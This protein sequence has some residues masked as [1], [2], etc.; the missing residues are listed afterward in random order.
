MEKSK[1]HT[2]DILMAVYYKDC[3]ILFDRAIESVYKNSLQPYRFILVVDGQLNTDLDCVI[4]K[5]GEL[6]NNFIVVRLRENLG[7]ANALNV[8]LT[9]S[10]AEYIIR[11][12]SDDYN[13]PDRFSI[14]MS[15][16]VSG[17]DVVGSSILEVDRLGN[18]LAVR[19][20][21]STH[22]DII[23]FS[24]KR[25][26]F[27]HMSVVFRSKIIKDVGGYPSI[28]LKEDYA[29]WAKLISIGANLCNLDCI[30]V[31]ATTGKDMYRRRGGLKYAM[32]EIEMQKFLMKSG[33][34]SFPGAIVDGLT[35]AFVFLLPSSIR[36]FIY[37][38]LLRQSI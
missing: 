13:L 23:K 14:L 28:Y 37:L 29:L 24:V 38:K 32:A 20:C 27:N 10:C 35:R 30:L 16:V 7:F 26:P 1:N 2:F 4:N 6:H 33:L 36:E 5:Y 3:P 8:G 34:K 11:C 9:N 12:D 31:H 15:K 19:R 22:A 18:K 25:N 21:P 17:Y